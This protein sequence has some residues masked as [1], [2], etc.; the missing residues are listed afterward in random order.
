MTAT[1]AA[2]MG[3]GAAAEPRPR[4]LG[5]EFRLTGADKPLLL[6][7]PQLS[8]AGGNKLS[9]TR[10]DF[11][12]SGL[13]LQ[14][15]DGSWLESRDWHD[16]VSMTAGRYR[17]TATG[18]P[19]EKF[20]AL[21][22][23]I[24]P[25]AA[26]NAG[27]PHVWEPGHPLHPQ[28]S[29]LHWGWQG[30]YIFMALEGHWPQ[31]DGTPGGWSWH[32]ATD[33]MRTKIE[34]PATIDTKTAR[35]VTITLNASKLAAA[36]DLLKDGATTHSRPGDQ[37]AVK[38]RNAL[39]QA[40]SLSGTGGDLFQELSTA[41]AAPADV[42]PHGTPWPLRIS[43]R[44]PRA[45][46]PADNLPTVEGVELGRRL[47]HE[48]LLSAGGSVSCVSCHQQE[49]AFADRD[50]ALSTGIR[51]AKGSRNAMPLFNLAWHDEFFW[52]G[53]VKGLRHQVLHPIADPVEMGQSPEKA[54]AAIA[55]SDEYRRLFARAFGD[56]TITPE[57]LGL[58][59]EQFLLTLISQ[60]SKFDKAARGEVKLTAEEQRG[61]ELF[62]TEHDPARGL[63]GADCFHCHG[64]NLF[65]SGQFAA[66]GL[67]EVYADRGRAKVTGNETDAG[68]FRIPSLRNIA[69]TAPYMHDGR[70][71][72]LEEV[73]AHYDHG[74]KRS[75]ALDP[76]LAKHPAAGLGLSAADQKALIAFLHTLTDES[77]TQPADP[78]PRP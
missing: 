57:R 70:F 65:T 72:T 78:A 38:L 61:L 27:D 33:A 42:K 13:A 68:K 9:V 48:P 74:V 59:L 35:T 7:Q 26:T 76:N 31:P 29:G 69:K 18:V 1:L 2:T 73:I 62:V 28:T 34:L 6:H 25:D 17:M 8:D 12:V 50:K 15:A 49:A 60:E 71:A 58:A 44:L 75:P 24:G 39:P 67:E 47:F 66:N 5:L 77:F 64:G 37:L 32:L 52:D 22:F 4:D 36:V 45:S 51:G 19:Q 41:P 46:I 30:G 10:F 43:S 16:L 3:F 53:R 54:A 11:L 63:F 40:F 56:E 23:Y 55:A 20:T 14:R 21:R